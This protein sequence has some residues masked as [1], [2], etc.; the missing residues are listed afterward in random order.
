MKW[1]CTALTMILLAHGSSPARAQVQDI[2]TVPADL[3]EKNPLAGNQAAVLAG[4][5]QFRAR[6]ADC[7][8][9]DARGA[10]GPD[11]TEVWASG[12]SDNG[13]FRTIRLGVPNTEMP[14]I[15]G[16]RPTDDDIWRILA[17]LRTLAAPAPTDAPKGNA[18]NGERLFRVH[19]ASCHRA[20]GRGG[21][22]GPDLSRVG[23]SRARSTLTRQI[24]GAVEEL[25]RGYEPVTI[26]APGGRLVHGVKKNEDLFSVQIMDTGERIQGYLREDLKTVTNEKKSAM[27]PFDTD[28]LSPSDLEDILAYLATLRGAPTTAPIV[29]R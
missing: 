16:D 20:D 24:R 9:M 28:K 18:Q 15:R 8:G 6:C 26:V 14:P 17:Y 1:T 25:G 13:L 29:T 7:H 4:M 2:P 11:I 23:V 22:L 3:P 27:P 12:R 21:R 19:C 5:S 10:R